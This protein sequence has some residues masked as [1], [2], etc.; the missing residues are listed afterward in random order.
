MKNSGK[1]HTRKPRTKEPIQQSLDD[2]R[3]MVSQ[4]SEMGY[5]VITAYH[6]NGGKCNVKVIFRGVLTEL[7]NIRLKNSFRKP[8][9]G[10]KL[11][12]GAIVLVDDGTIILV[13]KPESYRL[14]DASILRSLESVVRQLGDKCDVDDGDD[15]DDEDDP[16]HN[17]SSS[18]SDDDDVTFTDILNIP[19]EEWDI[20]RI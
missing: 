9:L 10:Q 18:E 12:V 11:Y 20:D 17:S 7:I 5:G 1:R 8:H 2:Y 19:H 3:S 15:V 16:Y 14:I 4:Q 6:G 13:Y